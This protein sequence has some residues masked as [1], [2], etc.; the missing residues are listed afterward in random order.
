MGKRKHLTSNEVQTALKLLKNSNL[1]NLEIANLIGCSIGSIEKINCAR[2]YISKNDFE[3][4]CDKI[5][6][7]TTNMKI[8]EYV[9]KNL[10]VELPEFAE[11]IR[12]NRRNVDTS[13]TSIDE[14]YAPKE[15]TN[16]TQ[17]D[18]EV[19]QKIDANIQDINV[20]LIRL[21]NLVELILKLDQ[22]RR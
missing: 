13:Q 12:D 11:R 4:L 6:L 18:R 10:G 14:Y 20:K 2:K 15:T 5:K 21:G 1:S 22:P 19:L 7:R 16:F 17:V 3:G 9:A 8:A